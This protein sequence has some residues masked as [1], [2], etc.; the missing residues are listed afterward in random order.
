[1][2]SLSAVKMT[3]DGQGWLVR[4]YNRSEAAIQVTLEP[5]WKYQA[6]Y[7]A[8]LAETAFGEPL[9]TMGGAVQFTAGPNEIVTI[10]FRPERA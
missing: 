3:E 10:I 7:R 4:G 2:Y 6:A 1:M 8:N 9:E 5:Q